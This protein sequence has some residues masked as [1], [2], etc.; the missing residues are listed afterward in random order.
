MS[1]SVLK[2]LDILALFTS[3]HHEFT[4]SA[5]SKALDMPKPTAYRLL[6]TLESRG[7]LR[8]QRHSEHDIRYVL[9]LKLLELGNL[10]SEKLEV[11]Q[12]AFPFMKKLCE[13]I[14]E[15][16]H[17]VIADES[18]AIYIEKVEG[19][20]ALRLHTNVGM[21]SALH[22]G[23]GPKLLLAFKKPAFIAHYL[24][25]TDFSA[26]TTHPSIMTHYDLSMEIEEIKRNGYSVSRGEQDAETIGVS[27]PVRDHT[28][29]VCAA[30]AVSGPTIRFFGDRGQHI[31]EETRKTA[32]VIS[33]Q[34]GYLA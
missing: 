15:D 1:Q 26:P 19:N 5:L 16:V 17:L 21:R 11:R 30:L 18:D 4:L 29:T 32:E 22:V 20:Q 28:G 3:E 33:Q 7:F 31:Q 8:K 12:V 9:G 6:T 10:V 2:A 14:N 34:L 13:E 25:E 24:E 27:Y 23:S